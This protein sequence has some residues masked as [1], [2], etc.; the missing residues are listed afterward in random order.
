VPALSTTAVHSSLWRVPA[1]STALVQPFS[2]RGVCPPLHCIRA[3][4][5][6]WRVHIVRCGAGMYPDDDSGCTYHPGQTGWAQVM[7]SGR[8]RGTAP[9]PT[10]AQVNADRSRRRLCACAADAAATAAG[11]ARGAAGASNETRA[12]NTAGQA[13]AVD[14][15][16]VGVGVAI[17]GGGIALLM[18]VGW[19]LWR[20]SRASSTPASATAPDRRKPTPCDRRKPNSA[21]ASSASATASDASVTASDEPTMTVPE[22]VVVA[23]EQP[24]PDAITTVVVEGTPLP[25]Y[26]KA[27]ALDAAMY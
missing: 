21:T 6:L 20:P 16:S 5:S 26:A 9:A 15:R 17:G 24:R 22:V 14:G 23:G 12:T 1:L 4:Y 27:A 7:H 3:L 11:G 2:P 25:S 8:D 18:I 19:L 13:S 10:C